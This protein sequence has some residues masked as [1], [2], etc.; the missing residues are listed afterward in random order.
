[1]QFGQCN[2][3]NMSFKGRNSSSQRNQ[4]KRCSSKNSS[5]PKVLTF[6]E[7]LVDGNSNKAS[8]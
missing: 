5:L 7:M 2:A 3:N 1:M 6:G 4:H 8:A